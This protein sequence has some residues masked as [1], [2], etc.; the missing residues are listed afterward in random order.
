MFAIESWTWKRLIHQHVYII[1]RKKCSGFQKRPEKWLLLSYCP[2]SL[3][4]WASACHKALVETLRIRALF[5]MASGSKVQTWGVITMETSTMDVVLT[6]TDLHTWTNNF[7]FYICQLL[8]FWCLLLAIL[9]LLR[10]FL[11]F[12]PPQAGLDPQSSCLD[13][14]NCWITGMHHHAQ[15]SFLRF[16][17]RRVHMKN[18]NKE[19]SVFKE[20]DF[21]YLTNYSYH[22]R[23]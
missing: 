11:S 15:L 5:R 14:S 13:L 12:S 19:Q 1:P 10:N 7:F 17:W 3:S 4:I 2:G 21:G 16:C 22:Y 8:P 20:F 23:V 6:T 9:L 18:Y